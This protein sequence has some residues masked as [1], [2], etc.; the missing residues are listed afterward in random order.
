MN[1]HT[2]WYMNVKQFVGICLNQQTQAYLVH[3]PVGDCVLHMW[4]GSIVHAIII[5]G[6]KL[7]T[8]II[9]QI[10]CVCV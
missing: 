1:V 6:F 4:W 3:S 8:V 7:S 9:I 5:H 2:E 10:V